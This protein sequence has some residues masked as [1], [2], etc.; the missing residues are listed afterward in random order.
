[1]AFPYGWPPRPCPSVRPLRFFASGT[2][3][4]AFSDNA[5]LF[6]TD[7]V[8]GA[9]APSANIS[10]MPV[11]PPGSTAP[12]TLGNPPVGGGS[13]VAADDGAIPEGEIVAMRYA[14]TI[15]IS[16]DSV[17]AGDNIEVSFDGTNVHGV[18]VPGE[19]RRYQDR[20]EAGIAIRT[21]PTKGN[22]AFRVEA[23]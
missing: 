15:Q 16:N 5:Y 12:T 9:L 8:S 13:P 21:Q 11:V 10:P 6:G 4:A 1:M 17:V 3:G 19:T 23:W 22:S 2:S 20:H 7:A 18:I 14:G